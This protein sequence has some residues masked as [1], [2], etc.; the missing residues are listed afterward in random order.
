MFRL[1]SSHASLLGEL[2]GMTASIPLFLQ[3]GFLIN[4]C[5]VG[6]NVK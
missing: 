1:K 2:P 4:V 6:A 5:L 3:G